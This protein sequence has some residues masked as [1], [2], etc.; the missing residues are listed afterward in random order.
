M[1]GFC[2]E[3]CKH[4]GLVHSRRHATK[5]GV[6]SVFGAVPRVRRRDDLKRF[7][8]VWRLEAAVVGV[9]S[10]SELISLQQIVIRWEVGTQSSGP[11]RPSTHPGGH[12]S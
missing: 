1:R 12:G 11:A 2:P 9:M 8:T 3:H 6:G 5:L 10:C 4:S 7:L